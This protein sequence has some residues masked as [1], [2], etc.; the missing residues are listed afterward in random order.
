[1]GV[2]GGE[3]TKGERKWKTGG[4]TS[5]WEWKWV[6]KLKITHLSENML[7]EVW[8]NELE[9][10]MKLDPIRD[11]MVQWVCLQKLH[12]RRSKQVQYKGQ[13]PELLSKAKCNK[14]EF[15]TQFYKVA[16]PPKVLQTA[17]PPLN[18]REVSS[19][20]HFRESTFSQIHVQSPQ[21]ATHKKVK[22]QK[23][24]QGM[25]QKLAKTQAPWRGQVIK[26][27]KGIDAYHCMLFKK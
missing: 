10:L 22:S 2:G 9:A 16:M 23:K 7:A 13:A 18:I 26:T 27:Q 17:K 12:E 14:Q 15:S 21:Y 3:D 4:M 5:E 8:Q 1:M 24:I 20:E 25:M 19:L 11:V 6:D